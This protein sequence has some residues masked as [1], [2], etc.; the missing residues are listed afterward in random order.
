[1]AGVVGRG[2]GGACPGGGALRAADT[3][4]TTRNNRDTPTDC[5]IPLGVARARHLESTAT[6]HR[7]TRRPC[8]K[9]QYCNDYCASHVTV[10]A[11]RSSPHTGAG[12]R[13]FF[14][15]RFGRCAYGDCRLA[16]WRVSYKSN[17]TILYNAE[18]GNAR[19]RAR[20]R[21]ERSDEPERETPRTLDLSSEQSLA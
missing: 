13:S 19:P 4:A 15:P 1:M 3:R 21:R 17:N 2:S 10:Y 12:L 16:R 14:C 18:S 8:K 20:A 5:Q 11:Q 7:L 9:R 6:G